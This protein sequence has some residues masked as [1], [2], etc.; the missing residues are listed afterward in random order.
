MFHP[1]FLIVVPNSPSKL[2]EIA[3]KFLAPAHYLFNAQKFDI[4]HE[5]PL[6][7][8]Y[9]KKHWTVTAAAIIAVVPGLLIGSILKLAAISISPDLRQL[10]RGISQHLAPAVP[11]QMDEH[12]PQQILVDQVAQKI[13]GLAPQTPDLE[14]KLPDPS[15]SPNGV[16]KIP[17]IVDSEQKKS[18]INAI[19]TQIEPIHPDFTEVNSVAH[20]RSAHRS[21]KAYLQEEAKKIDA[22][23]VFV[24]PPDY[25]NPW[26]N[27]VSIKQNLDSSIFKWE[28]TDGVQGDIQRDSKLRDHVVL[29]GV[30]SQF[31]CSESCMPET[32]QPGAAVETYRG[33]PTQGPGA[34]SQFSD[35]L[36]ER[37]NDAANIGYNGLC[38]VLDND[39][40]MT[41]K[42][43]YLTP[44]TE[45]LANAVIKQLQ[46]KGNQME[47]PCIGCIPKGEGNTEKVYEMLVSAPAFGMY[48]YGLPVGYKQKSE[49][50]F[51][52]SLHAYRAQFQQAIKLAEF[53]PEKQII[54]KP[55]APGLGVFSNVTMNIAKAFYVAAKEY[56]DQLKRNN[57][58]V[59]LQIFHGG[60]DT[61][62]MATILGLNEY[63]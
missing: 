16:D 61:R 47:F 51:L 40:K 12:T 6:Q 26:V 57:I 44:R 39:T 29:Y 49:I 56:E 53:F 24:S 50:E 32:P 19:P 59:R 30:A 10:F 63:K 2:N 43:G 23:V 60:G 52:C 31:N 62:D 14:I 7:Q 58:L 45:T 36:I 11:V 41:I 37:I 21:A 22:E 46:Q 1:A 15:P 34:Q 13:N 17:A 3:D 42:H 9:Q 54:F 35:E 5:P 38:H 18:P 48:S 27:K 25:D 20:Q 28:N 8:A 33:D 55:T 4:N